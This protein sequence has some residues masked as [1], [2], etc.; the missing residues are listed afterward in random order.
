MQLKLIS[1]LILLFLFTNHSPTEA[2]ETS[3]TWWM[4]G[5]TMA[6]NPPRGI[7][8]VK[9]NSASMNTDVGFVIYTPPGY[10]SSSTRY[11]VIYFLHGSNGH[12]WNYIGWFTDNTTSGYEELYSSVNLIS[13]IESGAVPP[14]IVVFPNGCRGSNYIDSGADKPETMII[15]ELIPY[16]DSNWRTIASREGRGLEGFSM[17][18]NGTTRFAFRYPEMFCSAIP[19]AGGETSFLSQNASYI[20]ENLPVRLVAGESDNY[21][22]GALANVSSALSAQNIS[23]QTQLIP[24]VGHNLFEVYQAA[25]ETGVNFHWDCFGNTSPD[26]QIFNDV[27]PSHPYFDEIEILYQQGYTSGCSEDPLLFCPNTAMNRGE[28]AV[29]V[30]R[31]IHGADMLPIEPQTSI[32]ADLEVG[33]WALKWADQLYQDGFTSGCGSDPLVYCPSQGHTRVEGSVFYLRM[34]NGADYQPPPAADLFSDMNVSDWGTRWAEAAFKAGLIPAC[35][36]NPLQFCSE[37]ALDR[38]LAAYMMVQAKGLK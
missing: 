2:A 16:V 25:G 14:T 17:G 1:A 37:G 18:A 7:E 35:N 15:Q 9:F 22:S 38:G 10:E 32:F 30:E 31:G 28:S 19:M 4:S 29:F 26:P 36:E 13:L 11:P 21:G 5:G 27:P 33:N 6:Q 23:H 34:L 12:E 20:R 8:H 3:C 24:G